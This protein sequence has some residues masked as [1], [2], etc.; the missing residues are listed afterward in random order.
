MSLYESTVVRGGE[1]ARFLPDGKMFLHIRRGPTVTLSQ[2][3]GR[4]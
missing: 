4:D 3:A 1:K 2:E